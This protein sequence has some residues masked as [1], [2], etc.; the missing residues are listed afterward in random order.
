MTDIFTLAHLSDPHLP[1]LPAAAV[2][3]VT[4]QRPGVTGIVVV[5]VVDAGVR[6][7]AATGLALGAAAICADDEKSGKSERTS[8]NVI[9][10]AESGDEL[11][12][13]IVSVSAL[14]GTSM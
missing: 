12:L 10:P 1:P 13:A 6:V 8:P 3:A 5:F 4:Y 9:G 2:C 11:L 14:G 7:Q